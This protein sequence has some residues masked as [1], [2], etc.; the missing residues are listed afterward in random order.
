MA[1]T[2]CNEDK[3][4]KDSNLSVSAERKPRATEDIEIIGLINTDETINMAQCGDLETISSMTLNF[5][6]YQKTLTITA[7]QP[8]GLSS[9]NIRE[10]DQET[11]DELAQSNPLRV[12][13]G[14]YTIDPQYTMKHLGTN[15]KVKLSSI[16]FNNQICS[17]YHIELV[18]ACYANGTI[19][20][21][22][23]II[24]S[25]S[26]MYGTTLACN[27]LD[28]N[29]ASKIDSMSIANEKCDINGSSMADVALSSSSVKSNG[30][31][32]LGGSVYFTQGDFTGD[33]ID[34]EITDT[35]TASLPS[36]ITPFTHPITFTNCT[37]EKNAIALLAES[38]G[39][40]NTWKGEGTVGIF[41]DGPQTITSGTLSIR[42]LDTAT[43][44]TFISNTGT[45]NIEAFS[46][47]NTVIITS[48][49]GS[50]SIGS[51]DN[52]Y[53]VQLQNLGKAIAQFYNSGNLTNT[54]NSGTITADIIK[55]ENLTNNQ[56]GVITSSQC[57]VTNGSNDG[58]M[59][60]VSGT[61][62]TNNTSGSIDV[63]IMMGGSSN[64]G[65]IQ[66]GI[67]RESSSND[68]SGLVQSAMFYDSA[69]NNGEIN[70]GSFYNNSSNNGSG[71]EVSFYDTSQN[72]AYCTKATFNDRSINN[73]INVNVANFYNSSKNQAA[74]TG[75]ADFYNGS[76]CL[77][78]F[79][80]G[81]IANF[82]E[83]SSATGTS[84]PSGSGQSV[85]FRDYSRCDG[86]T[87][88]TGSLNFYDNAHAFNVTINSTGLPYVTFHDNSIVETV[89][90][91]G[92]IILKDKAIS[93]KNISNSGT[94]LR[95]TSSHSGTI[96]GTLT[97]VTFAEQSYHTGL[98]ASSATRVFFID[99]SRNQAPIV[100]GGPIYFN[101]ST[102]LNRLENISELYF[103]NRAINASGGQIE[104]AALLVFDN[105]TSEH[106]YIN[107]STISGINN[108]QL[109]PLSNS[110]IEASLMD[111]STAVFSGGCRNNY[112]INGSTITFDGSTNGVSNASIYTWNIGEISASTVKFT[113]GSS[114]YGECS[115]STIT[116]SGSSVNNSEINGSTS[117]YSSSNQGVVNGSVIFDNSSNNN[118]FVGSVNGSGSI[119]NGVISGDCSFIE[120][121]NGG[122]IVG[123]C[124][125]N[126]YSVNNNIISGTAS[127]TN[128]SSHNGIIYG[129]AT[130]DATSTNNGQ[131]IQ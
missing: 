41:Y 24:G 13:H 118:L 63:A 98:G 77:S 79:G 126:Q 2:L 103:I 67:F 16:G 85:S 94:I 131:I 101:S 27:N 15:A 51:E 20:S 66:E 21:D 11:L 39:A 53:R 80:S 100:A 6:S 18:N 76:A 35:S 117:F 127:F 59:N 57:I 82:Y 87:F 86:I 54:V 17:S 61:N 48:S 22:T 91:I 102:N 9:D 128:Y 110:G 99:S 68:G 28:M 49:G 78:A 30:N 108:S 115:A 104:A 26:R 69:S 23:V 95:G 31:K 56:S 88:E 116:F 97:D 111:C 81:I 93:K 60:H 112:K 123:N 75:L 70:G 90:G 29:G 34:C 33:T 1:I 32:F 120:C 121:T 119:N 50:T 12:E 83:Y 19:D 3:Y 122:R 10:P 125:F 62:F 42:L 84:M 106:K 92:P 113:N 40:N 5:N 25:N 96:Q 72:N 4:Y 58:I 71:L 105:S 36:R 73:S 55:C 114:N 89:N 46:G 45:I 107:G 37:F 129:T 130:F 8:G 109:Y 74:I 65:K 38:R 43:A 124:S 14:W 64:Q 7:N 52:G 44:N 47:V